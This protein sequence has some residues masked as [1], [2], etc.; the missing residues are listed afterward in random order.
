MD[1]KASLPDHLV[2]FGGFYNHW[3]RACVMGLR[4]WA[5]VDVDLILIPSTECLAA[6]LPILGQLIS[7][8][9]G[10]R[11]HSW[12]RAQ[13][14]FLEK[15]I[16]RFEFRTLVWYWLMGEGI[17]CLVTS[18]MSSGLIPQYSFWMYVRGKRGYVDVRPWSINCFS[19]RAWLGWA[20]SIN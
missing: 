12:G 9:G 11:I 17:H 10:G 14:L 19:T 5:V 6:H 20:K 18:I 1:K 7:T 8:A 15:R 16:S 3:P 4:V 2:R 13:L